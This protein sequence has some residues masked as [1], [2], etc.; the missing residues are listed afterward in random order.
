MYVDKHDLTLVIY[1]SFDKLY[2]KFIFYIL[3]KLLGSPRGNLLA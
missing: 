3:W 2:I 1:L